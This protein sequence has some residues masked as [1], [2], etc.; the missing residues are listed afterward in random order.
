MA[1]TD[2][3]LSPITDP[4]L[5]KKLAGKRQFHGIP[6]ELLFRL[7]HHVTIFEIPSRWEAIHLIVENGIPIPVVKP[8]ASSDKK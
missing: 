2:I 5:L 4:N 3:S 8:P 7:A 6:D 1:I